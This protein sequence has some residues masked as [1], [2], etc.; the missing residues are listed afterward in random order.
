[1]SLARAA[2][3][4]VIDPALVIALLW[5]ADRQGGTA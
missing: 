4:A 1:M 5:Q 2:H 3:A